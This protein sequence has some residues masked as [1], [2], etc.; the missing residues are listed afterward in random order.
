[1]EEF[2]NGK[3]QETDKEVETEVKDGE[4]L[5]IEDADEEPKPEAESEFV[6]EILIESLKE[7]YDAEEKQEVKEE[8][9]C[10]LEVQEKEEEEVMNSTV[11]SDELIVET[12]MDSD[13]IEVESEGIAESEI[14]SN[15]IDETRLE[16]E[17]IVE[18]EIESKGIN[19]AE[20][21]PEGTDVGL[22]NGTRETMWPESTSDKPNGGESEVGLSETEDKI[23]SLL[24]ESATA[25]D[26]DA[27]EGIEKEVASLLN[28]SSG[29]TDVVTREVEEI[30]VEE[31]AKTGENSS[32]IVHKE[33]VKNIDDSPKPTANAIIF[34]SNDA[35]PETS[36]VISI[37]QRTMQPTTWRSCWGLFEVLKRSKR[38]DNEMEQ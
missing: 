31:N 22:L 28:E 6:T 7:S 29:F 25:A 11:D 19:E 27:P 12:L 1:M 17:G 8:E 23:S 14:R 5:V 36:H 3:I 32:V 30:N 16:S 34:G 37:S 26:N 10:I 9:S 38:C 2:S 35:F 21:E 18:A 20:V 33:S 4:E 13:A 15:G 24:S